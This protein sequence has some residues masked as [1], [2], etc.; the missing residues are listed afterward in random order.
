[1]DLVGQLY[2]SG[3]VTILEQAKEQKYLKNVS[4]V[5]ITVE[6]LSEGAW[7]IATG[8]CLTKPIENY[9]QNSGIVFSCRL[10]PAGDSLDIDELKVIDTSRSG[11]VFVTVYGDAAGNAKMMV[12]ESDDGTR[13]E[14]Y[15]ISD[16]EEIGISYF[17]DGS[18]RYGHNDGLVN[19]GYWIYPDGSRSTYVEYRE[20]VDGLTQPVWYQ[21][22]HSDGSAEEYFYE[23][24]EFARTIFTDAD[25]STWEAF[26]ENGTIVSEVWKD[27]DGN[28]LDEFG[29]TGATGATGASSGTNPDG[30]T[31]E[32]TL[33]P[34]GSMKTYDITWPDGDFQKLTYYENGN[35]ATVIS[36][37]DG[38]YQ[39]Y[40]YDENG[41]LTSAFS[42]DPDGTEHE[43]VYENG[44]LKASLTTFP[45]GDYEHCTNYENGSWKSCISFREGVYEEVYY[46][47]AGRLTSSFRRDPDGREFES[48]YE[49]GVS[50]SDF[51]TWP[52]GNYEQYTY[53]ENGSVYSYIAFRDGTYVENYHDENGH[54]TSVFQRDP[55]GTEYDWDYENGKPVGYT[56]TY[57]DG[58]TE[59]FE[60]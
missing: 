35:T 10:T 51:V 49:N 3:I 40:Y 45:N 23:N 34:S 33:Y 5:S 22:T 58:S 46:D 29:D 12:Y 55:D 18:Y 8:E 21:E 20:L 53:H 41:L 11:G 2:D 4:K 19:Q 32:Q 38:R 24:S 15:M 54:L 6:E 57:P 37:E 13:Q 31:F 59:Y 48:I 56:V 60:S 14:V 25:G 28:I 50:K 7:T 27:A 52:N 9:Q 43:S 16:T 30:S 39:E 1:M 36:F 47:I 42:R 44:T 17:P 26:Y